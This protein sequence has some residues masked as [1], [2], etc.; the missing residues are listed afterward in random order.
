MTDASEP[1]QQGPAPVNRL[2][3]IIG[4][5]ALVVIVVIGI[6]VVSSNGDSS[7][8]AA[9]GGGNGSEEDSGATPE[10]IKEGQT[11]LTEVGCYTGAIDGLYGPATDRAIRDFQRASGLAADGIFGPATLAALEE[12]VASG[13]TV[14]TGEST[15]D[16]AA[17]VLEDVQAPDG[18]T[19]KQLSI[20]SAA[21]SVLV[22]CDQTGFEPFFFTDQGS[23]VGCQTISGAEPRPGSDL[24]EPTMSDTESPVGGTVKLVTV[25][26]P[27]SS[28]LLACGAE[29]LEPFFF[30]DQGS[31][32]GCQSQ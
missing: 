26:G 4:A 31:W 7:T 12:A 14:C 13:E 2:P 32:V 20:P 6:M 9:A 25:P 28:V 30:T 23:W 29:G 27:E 24:T 11:A 22:E 15:P 21:T 5:V 16:A 3:W 19:V 8:D 10:Q 18:G 1:P 17:P